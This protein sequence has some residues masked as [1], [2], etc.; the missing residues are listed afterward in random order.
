MLSGTT[1]QRKYIT[2][3]AGHVGL[4]HW[5][6]PAAVSGGEMREMGLMRLRFL[7]KPH[8]MNVSEKLSSNVSIF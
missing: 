5:H 6:H 8:L 3:A 1:T 7:S 4:A 2:T